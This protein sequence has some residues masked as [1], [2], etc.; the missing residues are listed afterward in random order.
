MQKHIAIVPT[1]TTK[2]ASSFLTPQKFMNK[3][4][5]VSH[6]VM[7]APSHKGS[8]NSILRAIAVPMTS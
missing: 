8:P 7:I 4:V 2:K 6:I 5:M 1:K 3:N